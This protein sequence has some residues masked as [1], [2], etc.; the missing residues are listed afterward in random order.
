MTV[1]SEPVFRTRRSGGSQANLPDAR[2]IVAYLLNARP[3][4]LG[5]A[6][7]GRAAEHYF[8]GAIPLFFRG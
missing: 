2:H 7:E 5:T 1:N 3:Y 8:L 4:H 6:R